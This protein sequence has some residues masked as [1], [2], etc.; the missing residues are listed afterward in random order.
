METPDSQQENLHEAEADISIGP[1]PSGMPAVTD[2]SPEDKIQSY[3]KKD[4]ARYILRDK[5]SYHCFDGQKDNEKAL[6]YI[7]KHWMIQVI[8]LCQAIFWMALPFGLLVLLLSYFSDYLDHTITKLVIVF[9]HLAILF[10]A[11]NWFI[12]WLD[13]YLDVIII[14]NKRII[15]INQTRIFD[16]K[17]STMSLGQIQDVSG[18]VKGFIPSVL[19]Y[20]VLNIETAGQ[21][22]LK[23]LMRSAMQKDGKSISRQTDLAGMGGVFELRYV[24]R[25]DRVATAILNIR[26]YYLKRAGISDADTQA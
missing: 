2:I 15:D 26:D 1:V 17:I 5:Y 20:G 4:L 25:C 16:R 11:L 21:G 3:F 14:T 13:H 19:K 18:Q 6:L 7:R 8:I 23:E 10:I 24:Y 9:L 12:K 22:Q